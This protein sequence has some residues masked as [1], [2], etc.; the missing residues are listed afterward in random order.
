[1]PQVIVNGVIVFL[2]PESVYLETKIMILDF[3]MTAI[4]MDVMTAVEV[5]Y[6]IKG[7]L[8]Q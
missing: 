6:I 7:N 4:K 8:R 3:Y 5:V 2:D 1:M